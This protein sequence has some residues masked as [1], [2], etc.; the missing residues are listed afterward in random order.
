MTATREPSTS[1][2]SPGAPPGE[3]DCLMGIPGCRLRSRRSGFAI[4][5]G[6]LVA[7]VPARQRPGRTNTP[8]A[9][10]S[11]ILTLRWRPHKGV[12]VNTAHV[13][14]EV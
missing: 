8:A 7:E 13:L 11:E 4:A 1:L 2:R 3:A 6:E 10:P 5:S 9:G 12:M 14:K